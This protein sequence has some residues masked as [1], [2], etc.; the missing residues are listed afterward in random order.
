VLGL[1]PECSRNT[2]LHCQRRCQ[3]IGVD[4][5]YEGATN[6]FPWMAK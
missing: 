4:M 1:M 5:P 3:Q 2:A 6:P